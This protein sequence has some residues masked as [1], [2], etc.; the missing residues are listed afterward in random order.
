M[1]NAIL[2]YCSFGFLLLALSAF[3]FRT[4]IVNHLFRTEIILIKETIALQDEALKAELDAFISR[5]DEVSIQGLSKECLRITRN[6]LRFRKTAKSVDPNE[7]VGERDTHCVGYAA[8]FNTLLDYGL[9]QSGLDDQYATAHVRAK[10]YCFGTELTGR[11]ASFW[12]DHDYVEITGKGARP[13]FRVDPSLYEFL[14]IGVM[15]R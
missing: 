8:F 10:I 1:K 12:N 15:R 13:G 9:K 11:G 5:G 4:E 3:A 7:L 6:K 14:G 2:K